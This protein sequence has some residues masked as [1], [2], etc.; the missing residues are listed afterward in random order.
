MRAFILIAALAVLAAA[1]KDT[2]RLV[3]VDRTAVNEAITRVTTTSNFRYADDLFFV[4]S[5]PNDQGVKRR[6][7]NETL[8]LLKLADEG[9]TGTMK[10]A[11]VHPTKDMLY[12][13]YTRAAT[14]AEAA[15]LNN[16]A[17]N[18]TS[19]MGVA[20]IDIA[21]VASFGLVNGTLTT[22]SHAVLLS[23]P[24]YGKLNTLGAF[25]FGPDGKLW[26]GTANNYPMNDKQLQ[27]KD[28]SSLQGKVLRIDV[29]ASGMAMYA[30][31]PFVNSVTHAA[32]YATGFRAPAEFAFVDNNV[33]VADTG[34]RLAEEVNVV[35][36]SVDYGWPVVEGEKC[37][38]EDDCNK[39]NKREPQYKFEHEGS[40]PFAITGIARFGDEYLLATFFGPE[41]QMAKLEI[42]DDDSEEVSIVDHR[43]VEL[44]WYYENIFFWHAHSKE[45]DAP[46]YVVGGWMS[47]QSSVVFRAEEVEEMED[48]ASGV[49]FSVLVALV[50]AL[51][52]ALLH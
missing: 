3:E 48:A 28:P 11:A 51:V 15:E 20:A 7:G 8:A 19:R 49:H 18:E 30:G 26:I 6:R 25:S 52:A 33:Y 35:S 32:V 29:D 4:V 31:N 21:V 45:A 50:V 2:I 40:T 14:A 23:F 27:N 42:G 22:G 39:K 13:A 36:S 44:R 37:L 17:R 1:S 34:D 16:Y 47:N 12:V 9:I 41:R 24:V 38:L 5:G 43:G 10:A 46:T